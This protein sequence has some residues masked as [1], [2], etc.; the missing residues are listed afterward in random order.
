MTGS[1]ARTSNATLLNKTL[2]QCPI[3]QYKLGDHAASFPGCYPAITQLAIENNCT[4][5][6][7]LLSHDAKVDYA[8][9]GAAIGGHQSLLTEMKEKG[10]TAYR[11]AN[12]AALAGNE[13]L[14]LTLIARAKAEDA[15]PGDDICL[16][17]IALY[18]ACAKQ[19]ALVATLLQNPEVNIGWVL[20]G[21]AAA[22]LCD[23]KLEALLVQA[24]CSVPLQFYANVLAHGFAIGNH[25]HR[26][27]SIK[28]TYLSRMVTEGLAKGGWLE[29]LYHHLSD[30]Q[31]APRLYISILAVA[32][33]TTVQGINELPSDSFH[34]I[35]ADYQVAGLMAGGHTKE[36]L[37]LAKHDMN[38]AALR[39]GAIIGGFYQQLEHE[40]HNW[41]T[42]I[43][44]TDEI[45]HAARKGFT[46][47]IRNR[48]GA[49]GSI[50]DDR[51]TGSIHNC[52]AN[53]FYQ[54]QSQL[55][56]KRLYK[57][58][59]SLG[60]LGDPAFS[61]RL[62]NEI[63]EHYCADNAKPELM[64]HFMQGLIESGN[65]TLDTNTQ[66]DSAYSLLP[67]EVCAFY[68]LNFKG[69]K[70]IGRAHV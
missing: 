51:L 7:F 53:C 2:Q 32:G 13:P 22:N 37:E 57:Y 52:D 39:R 56:I 14:V 4:A 24:N 11:I 15:T 16:T 3:D 41:P 31:H 12:G 43:E 34:Q 69:V 55:T 66:K 67:Q 35:D 5:V 50:T 48:T 68:I 28:G 26:L 40:P 36:A 59:C 64:L 9:F 63:Y 18:A 42:Y 19:W 45:Y 62:F 29:D 1:A 47:Y 27:D 58:I 60:Q 25:L 38:I 65:L 6:R 61:V 70:E 49:I 17:E 10:A 54:V 23:E 33:H 44:P 46:N 20:T 30:Q 8:A 21:A